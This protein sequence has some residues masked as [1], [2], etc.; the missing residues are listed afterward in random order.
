MDYFTQNKCP[1]LG[2]EHLLLLSC[3]RNGLEEVSQRNL[4]GVELSTAN[5]LHDT[6]S[7]LTLHL[8]SL[9]Q[10][11]VVVQLSLQLA[12]DSG[13]DT[14]VGTEVRRLQRPLGSITC[15]IL[16]TAQLETEL[17]TRSA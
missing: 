3:L 14:D 8:T 13:T 7:I 10:G 15:P 6:S 2:A 16:V 12:Q 17:R 4:P 11:D 1:T 5:L 9:A